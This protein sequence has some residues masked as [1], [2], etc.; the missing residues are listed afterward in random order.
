MPLVQTGILKCYHDFY[1]YVSSYTFMIEVVPVSLTS[2]ECVICTQY[3]L[4]HTIHRYVKQLSTQSLPRISTHSR[5]K[6][7]NT[8]DSP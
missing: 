1:I 4:K 2:L 7:R 6:S 5:A 3:P 8:I